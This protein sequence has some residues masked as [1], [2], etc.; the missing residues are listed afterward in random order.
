LEGGRSL[1]IVDLFNSAPLTTT[2]DGRF[3]TGGDVV[4][5][6]ANGTPLTNG[7][8]SF[9]YSPPDSATSK[10]KDVLWP[11]DA[12]I[13]QIELT[14]D[15]RKK[16]ATT[17]LAIT[18]GGTAVV[19]EN[20][21]GL[22]LNI[23]RASIRLQPNESHT[24]EVFSYEFGRP[25]PKLPDGLKLHTQLY[26]DQ[27]G[28]ALPTTIFTATLDPKPVA[29]GHFR[30]L[31][32]TGPAVPLTPLREPLDSL[33]CF[34]TAT[35]SGYLIGEAMI[36]KPKTGP[37]T[38]PFLTLLFWQNSKVVEQPTWDA[39]IQRLMAIYAR[40]FPGMTSILDISDLATVTAN[41]GALINR[42][43]RAR[44]D[45]GFMPV[46]RDMSPATVDMMLRFLGGLTK[47]QS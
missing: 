41:A 35:G 27:T 23:E 4:I 21:N 18:A 12:A 19:Q 28:L 24:F 26:H 46:S 17:P 39:N 5:G 15:E 36:L 38:P 47:E 43:E 16:I 44:S 14:A 22:Y 45:P 20:P 40:L 30:L 7:A 2:K 31:V 11:D 37:P 3:D 42:F 34:L 10:L 33:L 25:S 32:K 6:W 13:F 1:L 29:P 8:I 9:R